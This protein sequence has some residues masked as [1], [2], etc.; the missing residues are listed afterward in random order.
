M[1]TKLYSIQVIKSI[2][3]WNAKNSQVVF[4][5]SLSATI[6][7][8]CDILVSPLQMEMVLSVIKFHG[9]EYEEKIPDVGQY[10]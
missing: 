10:V 1:Q 7:K 6:H 4:P 5:A 3:I 2:I 8:K 9:M